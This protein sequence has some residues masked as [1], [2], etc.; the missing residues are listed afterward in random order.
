MISEAN[1]Q[2]VCISR[3]EKIRAGANLSTKAVHHCGDTSLD[4]LEQLRKR[5]IAK[6]YTNKLIKGLLRIDSP[7]HKSYERSLHCS[8][9]LIQKEGKLTSRYCGH[10]W[11]YIC[12]RI[13]TAKLINGYGPVLDKLPELRF[14]TLSRPN[15]RGDM[16]K[17][18]I[19]S[20]TSAYRRIRDRLRKHKI[21]LK[22]VRKLEITYN[23]KTKDYHPHFHCIISGEL[24]AEILVQAWLL[25]NTTADIKAQDNRPA[26]ANSM[27]EIFKYVSKF[28]D[29]SAEVNDVIFKAVRGVRMVQSMGGIKQINE[30]I[31]TLTAEAYELADD[32]FIWDD[33][34]GGDW[35][36]VNTGIALTD[37]LKVELPNVIFIEPI[38][39]S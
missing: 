2:K 19:K 37:L 6:G 28:A 17:A 10:R 20:L 12:N 26:D 3:Q 30:D 21:L 39:S 24:E 32:V 31:E 7:L 5:Q 22:G 4:K 14:I 33:A 23:H 11:C 38:N 16:L 34:S 27:K 9:V 25:D 35:F 36:S 15:V 8:E 13:R 29:N 18:E 1:L